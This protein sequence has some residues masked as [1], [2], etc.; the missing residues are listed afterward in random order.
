MCTDMIHG[1]L[2]LAYKVRN[3]HQP[4]A[5]VKLLLGQ[6]TSLNCHAYTVYFCTP[7]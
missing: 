3:F 5:L 1:K 7:V 4:F 2:A 6:N